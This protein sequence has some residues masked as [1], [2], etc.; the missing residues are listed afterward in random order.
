MRRLQILRHKFAILGPLAARH[1]EMGEL[2]G[3][4]ERLGHIRLHHTIQGDTAVGVE[5]RHVGI[6]GVAGHVH[7]I[8]V[9][10]LAGLQGHG[11]VELQLGAGDVPSALR[12]EADRLVR[13]NVRGKGQRSHLWVVLGSSY[14]DL[15]LPSCYIVHGCCR[16]GACN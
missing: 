11:L 16:G 12:R 7:S 3:A 2:V 5:G 9:V 15:L 14:M 1:V 13:I 4:A 6:R 10:V 8:A